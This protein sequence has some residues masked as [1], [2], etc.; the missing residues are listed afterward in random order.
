MINAKTNQNQDDKDFGKYSKE[1]VN[2]RESTVHLGY[3]TGKEVE[4]AGA[5]VKEIEMVCFFPGENFITPEMYAALK[6]EEGNRPILDKFLKEP[7]SDLAQE[8]I[9][10]MRNER[11]S[12]DRM[13][14]MFKLRA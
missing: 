14:K 4:V 13:E 11:S 10:S 5:K 9:D 7:G 3:Q 12:A 6:K 8:V 1:L 2:I